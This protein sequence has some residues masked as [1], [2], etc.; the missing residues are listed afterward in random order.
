MY[1]ELEIKFIRKDGIRTFFSFK[2]N[3]N[4][5]EVDFIKLSKVFCLFT[6][7]VFQTD[8]E[9]RNIVYKKN[10]QYYCE[11]V[12]DLC[13]YYYNNDLGQIKEC[14]TIVENATFFSY[15]EFDSI[16]G[17]VHYNDSFSCEIKKPSAI[18]E[19]ESE[20]ESDSET[21]T[22]SESKS[23]RVKPGIHMTFD[24]SNYVAEAMVQ[25]ESDKYFW[26]FSKWKCILVDEIYDV[27]RELEEDMGN[28]GQ[29]ISSK[30]ETFIKGFSEERYS[31]F[32]FD[33]FEISATEV[34]DSMRYDCTFT[35]ING[36]HHAASMM[37]QSCTVKYTITD[38]ELK[39]INE[40]NIYFKLNTE[41]TH[42]NVITIYHGIDVL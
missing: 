23:K 8:S 36:I 28:Y 27:S 13:K 24:S 39:S 40:V 22:E 12:D 34:L 21:E 33:T 31:I 11:T 30:T 18:F 29:Y 9:Y 38:I 1:D 14:E 10:N 41:K 20:S 4:E 26:H 6:V 19:S 16:I 25:D 42:Y 32:D 17:H 15:D 3:D 35:P 2:N 5:T 7:C 37:A